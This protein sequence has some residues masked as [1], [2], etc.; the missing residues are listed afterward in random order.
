M[1]KYNKEL[2]DLH[3]KIQLNSIKKG[4]YTSNKVTFNLNE[5][6]KELEHADLLLIRSIIATKSERITVTISYTVI[7]NDYTDTVTLNVFATENIDDLIEANINHFVS[8]FNLCVSECED[9]K[10]TVTIIID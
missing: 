4:G 3:S 9:F 2:H 8:D 7:G 10:V 1:K 6:N 5:N